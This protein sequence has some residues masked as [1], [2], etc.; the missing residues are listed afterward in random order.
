MYLSGEM[1]SATFVVFESFKV[2]EECSFLSEKMPLGIHLM[3]YTRT[4]LFPHLRWGALSN[5]NTVGVQNVCTTLFFATRAC[6]TNSKD[7]I[8]QSHEISKG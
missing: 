3:N 7:T 4:S 5:I 8:L 1:Y 6:G 2:R